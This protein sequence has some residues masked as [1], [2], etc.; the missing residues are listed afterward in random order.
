MTFKVVTLRG[1]FVEGIA[2]LEDPSL[3]LGLESPLGFPR[4]W[5]AIS[6]ILISSSLGA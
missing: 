2:L 3:A 1:E 5:A 4:V 6:C